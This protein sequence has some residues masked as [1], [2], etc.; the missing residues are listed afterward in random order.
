MSD[1]KYQRKWRNK[2]TVDGWKYVSW[3]IPEQFIG[4]LTIHKKYL[5]DGI[6]KENQNSFNRIIEL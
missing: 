3:L 1:N 5:M 2:K 4:P 6:K